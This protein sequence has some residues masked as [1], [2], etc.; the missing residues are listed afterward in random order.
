MTRA[1]LAPSR[2]TEVS[3]AREP[4]RRTGRRPSARGRG[5]TPVGVVARGEE[6][7]SGPDRREGE[8]REGAGGAEGRR[9]ER[10]EDLN[11]P[12]AERAEQGCRR[13]ARGRSGRAGPSWIV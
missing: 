5:D 3:G 2:C 12:C 10:Q 8:G 13:N 11:D 9:E 1:A 6:A 7:R 4:E